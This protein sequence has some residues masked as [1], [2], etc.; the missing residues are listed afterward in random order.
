MIKI[1]LIKII[2][3]KMMFNMDEYHFVDELIQFP[4][5]FKRERQSVY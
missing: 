5:E 2:S 4:R 3:Y 1:Y